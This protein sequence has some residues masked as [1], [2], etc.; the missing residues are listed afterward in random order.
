MSVSID[1]IMLKLRKELLTHHLTVRQL[2][3]IYS[4]I[5]LF[6]FVTTLYLCIHS[7]ISSVLHYIS[8]PSPATFCRALYIHSIS[9]YILPCT[10]YP[11]SLQLRSSV[12]YISTL[13][14]ATFCR[15]LYI[16]C[17]S[18]YILPCI[19]YPLYLHLPFCRAIYIHCI[20]SYPIHPIT[21]SINAVC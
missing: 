2:L 3:F 5:Y 6:I 20:S 4:F 11:L 21:S 19:I 13:S 8:T 17:I 9:S 7:L 15:A 16:H 18:S 14:P 12:Y 10:L 1:R